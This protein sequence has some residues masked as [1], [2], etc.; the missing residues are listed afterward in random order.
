MSGKQSMSTSQGSLWSQTT[1]RA[2]FAK[3]HKTI[4]QMNFSSSAHDSALFT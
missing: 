2:W 4:T 1:P 3:F